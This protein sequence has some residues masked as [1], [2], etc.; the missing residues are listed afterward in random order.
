M[1]L[2]NTLRWQLLSSGDIVLVAVSG[3]PDSL[4]LLHVLWTEREARQIASIEA[5]HL[6]HGLRGE[7]SAAEAEWVS[8]WCA[9]HGIVCH[10]G[11]AD[12]AAHA[13][14]HRQS[15]QEAA[16][17]VRYAF[18]E[19][20]AA[21]IG[22]D[23]IATGHTQ[24]DQAETV[25]GNILRGTGLDGLR[26]IPEQRGLIIRPLLDVSR[27]EI[28]AY[29]AVN[30]L[31]PR[32]D[33][34]NFT[35]DHYTRNRIR[36]E[37]LPQLR[38]EYNSGVDKALLRLSEI[39]ARDSDYLTVQAKAALLTATQLSLAH[40]RELDREALA[41]L[42]PALL[43]YV[44]RFALADLRGTGEGVNYELL[45]TVCYAVTAMTGPAFTLTFPHPLC[46]VR[47]ADQKVTLSL[48]ST[49]ASADS[50]SASLPVPGNVTLETINETV[51]ADWE[52]HTGAIRVDAE[53]V[54]I[55]SLMVRTRR[56]GDQIDPL[57]MGG[58]HKKLSHIFTDAKFPRSEREH[59]PI[60]ADARGIVW[61]AGYTLS[62]R[63]K[64]TPNT[65]KVL[66][67]SAQP[68]TTRPASA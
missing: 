40:Y 61:V 20:T 21:A 57:G 39:A 26:G 51:W 25:L 31:L 56:I 65:T 68:P 46:R 28:E 63:A 44:L 62:E 22:A 50:P 47:V 54:D 11:K 3:G 52:D 15:T 59:V 8:A 36:L 19:Q 17:G 38:R 7:E 42:H 53:A 45:E 32:Q 29:C 2:T 14:E 55:G 1:A 33:P 67:L 60:I 9:E 35:T 41:A 27:S 5:A 64:V 18:L 37:L 34:S 4:S 30:G 43:Q 49:P 66:Y 58:R 6:D 24:D 12:A 10:V 48:A 23:K 13:R 16:R